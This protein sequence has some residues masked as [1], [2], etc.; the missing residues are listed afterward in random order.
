[1]GL[2]PKYMDE[3]LKWILIAVVSMFFLARLF[4]PTVSASTTPSYNTSTQT[5]S[6]YSSY[7]AQ[8][9]KKQVITT[10]IYD[11][12]GNVVHTANTQY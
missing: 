1:M 3:D 6:A 11:S 9:I 8:P 4:G 12:Y 2:A 10:K 7:T 5:A